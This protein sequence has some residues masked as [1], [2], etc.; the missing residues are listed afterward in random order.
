MIYAYSI[1]GMT[2]ISI[3]TNAFGEWRNKIA[4]Q[5][6]AKSEGH[7][8]RQVLVTII[9]R[10]TVH[11]FWILTITMSLKVMFMYI[12]I[13]KTFKNRNIEKR[14]VIFT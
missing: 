4:L 13:F 8:L 14:G 7:V 9:S 6:L 10:P 3:M 1:I 5:T 11:E 12:H 2:T